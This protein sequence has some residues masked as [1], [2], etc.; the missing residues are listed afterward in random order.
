MN[1]R[2]IRKK[3][4]L[5]PEKKQTKRV[6]T[7]ER[8][9]PLGIVCSACG[10]TIDDPELLDEAR[11]MR[12]ECPFCGAEHKSLNDEMAKAKIIESGTDEDNAPDN[13]E[14]EDA[15]QVKHADPKDIQRMCDEFKKKNHL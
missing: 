6:V 13:S 9:V 2:I 8:I 10:K 5:Q 14:G 4:K 15:C 7:R 11:S 1:V 3:T 12:W